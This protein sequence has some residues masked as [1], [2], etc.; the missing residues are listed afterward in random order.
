MPG[1]KSAESNRTEFQPKSAAEEFLIEDVPVRVER[2]PY[3]VQSG[4]PSLFISGLAYHS[5]VGAIPIACN[6]RR[7]PFPILGY[8][9]LKEAGIA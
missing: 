2:G 1:A 6:G 8:H 9:G 4:L 5:R 3:I 7:E